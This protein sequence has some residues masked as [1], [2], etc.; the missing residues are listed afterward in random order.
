MLCL[1]HFTRTYNSWPWKSAAERK[2]LIPGFQDP[3]FQLFNIIVCRRFEPPFYRQASHMS[4]PIFIFFP[5]PMLL[6]RLF[7]QYCP[8]KIPGKNKNKLINWHSCFFIF[9]RIKINVKYFFINNTFISNT[10][11]RFNPK[12]INILNKWLAE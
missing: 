10:R 5:N 6:A 4:I 9:R 7:Q 3:S 8:N 11:L 12:T 2:L 1:P